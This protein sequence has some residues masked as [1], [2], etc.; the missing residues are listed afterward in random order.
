MSVVS[1]AIIIALPG[2]RRSQYLKRALG[3]WGISGTVGH[4]ERQLP[5]HAPVDFKRRLIAHR[6]Q[7]AIWELL[8][9]NR[10]LFRRSNSNSRENRWHLTLKHKRHVSLLETQST[11]DKRARSR[12]RFGL[13]KTP[14]KGK[15]RRH[16]L[17]LSVRHR[18]IKIETIM[19]GICSHCA[20]QEVMELGR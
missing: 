5:T 16:F 10:R 12:A 6:P 7:P 18:P 1:G 17:P 19:R 13:P 2:T 14:R 20:D 8:E 4:L 9:G 15:C 11:L 3:N